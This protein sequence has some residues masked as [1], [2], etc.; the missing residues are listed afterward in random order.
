MSLAKLKV[1]C[2]HPPPFKIKKMCGAN[3]PD[4][5]VAHQQYTI[6]LLYSWDKN[7]CVVLPRKNTRLSDGKTYLIVSHTK[8]KSPI[9]VSKQVYMR[10]L[11][12]FT[13]FKKN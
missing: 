7:D 2:S 3:N 12:L 5:R 9:V 6:S 8:I 4:H 1:I 11:W 10:Y 13:A